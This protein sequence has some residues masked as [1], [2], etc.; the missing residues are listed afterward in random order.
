MKVREL[1]M[2]LKSADPD[3][4]VYMTTEDDEWPATCITTEN[5]FSYTPR[6][7]LRICRTN[8]DISRA[9][10][11]LHDDNP[12][13][14]CP[15]SEAARREGCTCTMSHVHSA[16]VDPPE[17]RIDQCCPLHGRDPDAER[18]KRRDDQ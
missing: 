12:P 14:L 3:G 8:A 1:M 7:A 18:E 13:D 6:R 17:P 10:T 5:K 15:C 4:I 9:E 11:V 2:A 16:S